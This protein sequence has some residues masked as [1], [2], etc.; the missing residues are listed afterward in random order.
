MVRGSY[1]DR[2]PKNPAA[3]AS[4]P[5]TPVTFLSM[6]SWADTGTKKSADITGRG[7]TGEVVLEEG[8]GACSFAPSSFPCSTDRWWWWINLD[9]SAASINRIQLITTSAAAELPTNSYSRIWRVELLPSFFMVCPCRRCWSSD[10]IDIYG[11]NIMQ[12]QLHIGCTKSSIPSVDI[13]YILMYILAEV[14]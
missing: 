9:L 14:T 10:W 12:S 5:I 7:T 11:N 1:F 6:T 13:A 8:R 2:K 4:S 3:C